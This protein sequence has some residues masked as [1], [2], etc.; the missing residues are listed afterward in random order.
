MGSIEYAFD[1]AFWGLAAMAWYRNV[2][3]RAIPGI[4]YTQSKI[5][6]WALATICIIVGVILTNVKRRNNFSILINVL[7][8][9]EVYA[10]ISFKEY[11]FHCYSWFFYVA[12]SLS[13]LY[14]CFAIAPSIGRKKSV[15]FARCFEHGFLGART[16]AVCCI[17]LVLAPAALNGLFGNTIVQSDITPH[18]ATEAKVTIADNIDTVANL[19]E[20]VWKGLTL[21]ERLDTL[22]VV[23]N[24][25]C[26]Y[27]GLPHGLTVGAEPMA[28]H[29]IAF[30]RDDAQQIRINIECLEN[31]PASEML[32][33]V[34]HEAYHAYQHRLCDAWMSVGND[35]KNLMAFSKVPE[36]M[37]NFENYVEGKEDFD[38]YYALACEQTARQYAGNAVKHY[39]RQ[40]ENCPGTD[41]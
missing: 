12:A 21:Q 3:F 13:T 27:L 9:F 4:P 35:Y 33:A 36:Y 20:D 19:R 39:Y 8:P 32:N 23:A 5:I 17:A 28:D 31:Q 29:T 26:S 14:F 22:Q 40:I 10:V 16:V 30:Y 38:A 1:N 11:L 41:S 15:R 18:T 25:E 2:L 24:I 6:L 34:C 7:T 37:D